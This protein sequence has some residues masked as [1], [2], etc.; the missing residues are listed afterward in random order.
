MCSE[1]L[2][3]FLGGDS[4]AD[5]VVESSG[6]FTT[7]DSASAHKKGGAK[8][9]VISPPSADAAMFVVRVNETTYKSNMD[10]VYNASCTTNFLAPLGKVCYKKT[11]DEPSMKDWHGGHG[12]T[13]NIVPSSIGA[14][15]VVVKVLPELNGKLTGMAFRVPTENVSVVD[16]T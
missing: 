1:I 6:V 16:L 4:G 8:K 9:V 13:Q 2:Q 10:I 5:Y 11:V 7:L 3:R 12:A 15:K 14:A